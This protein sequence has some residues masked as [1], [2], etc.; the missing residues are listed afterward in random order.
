MRQVVVDSAADAPWE[1][2][3]RR[4]V[5]LVSEDLIRLAGDRGRTPLARAQHVAAQRRAEQI[6]V[7]VDQAVVLADLGLE[8]LQGVPNAG[9]LLSGARSE[10][11]RASRSPA[12][13]IARFAR[14]R[15]IRRR[16]SHAQGHRCCLQPLR[17]THTQPRLRMPRDAGVRGSSPRVGSKNTSGDRPRHQAVEH[18]AVRCR[19]ERPDHRRPSCGRLQQRWPFTTRRVLSLSGIALARH[20]QLARS[21]HRQVVRPRPG[22]DR[23]S[24]RREARGLRRLQG[25][26][27]GLRV[28]P[29]A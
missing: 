12:R 9:A 2:C 13:L 5:P 7:H 25:P 21:R 3:A 22:A 14:K 11:A 23:E 20:R 29:R 27:D 10:P 1:R 26:G 24:G 15:V 18:R 4:A 28:R 17:L 6:A 16:G 19:A 8:A